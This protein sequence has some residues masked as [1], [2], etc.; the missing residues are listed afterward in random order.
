MKV[1]LDTHAMLWWWTAPELLS[2]P[3]LKI[4]SN[5][6]TTILASAVS[7]YEMAYKHHC[8]KLILPK[9]LMED[10]AAV[11]AQ[12][13]WTELPVTIEHTLLAGRLPSPHRDPFDRLLG[14]QAIQEKANLV[15][16]DPAFKTFPGLPVLW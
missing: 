8:G 7:A 15:T 1:L 10:F 2:K 13:R 4:L 16:V 9:G 12:E 6:A 3:I 5:P 14:A 11:L